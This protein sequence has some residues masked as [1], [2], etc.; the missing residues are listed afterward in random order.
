LQWKQYLNSEVTLDLQTSFSIEMGELGSVNKIGYQSAALR[1]HF[2]SITL[3]ICLVCTTHGLRAVAQK[4]TAT[5]VSRYSVAD[6]GYFMA[7]EIDERPGLNVYGHVAAWQVIGQTHV[8][9]A[10]VGAEGAKLI[11]GTPESSNS[12]AFGISDD[13]DL[14]GILESRADLRYTQ[15]FWYRDG[16]L[17]ILPTLG[18]GSA[19]AKSINRKGLV[20]GNA[21]TADHQ[22]HAATWA[23][24]RVHDLGT[25]LGG[26][27]SRAFDANDSGDI[28]GEAN[29]TVNGKV[30]AVLWSRDR[31][32][33]L[34][35]LPGGSFSSAQ[36]VN[37]KHQVVGFAD[38]ADGGSK[39]VLFWGGRVIDLGSLGDDPSS[40]L[41]INDAGQIV[42]TSPLAEGKM[43]A[44]LWEAGHLYNLNQLI[45]ERS[46]WL[47]LTAYQINAK[48]QILAY[49]FHEGR[50]HA[51][52]LTPMAPP[53]KTSR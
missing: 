40:A 25:L 5:P 36:A 44:F 42:G 2:F 33:D 53:P 50:T 7:R 19:A 20:V 8:D 34:G 49:G 14:V 22:T 12:F 47:L 24:G 28:A 46:G 52:L 31:I 51:C 3:S 21:Q 29:A 37:R 32:H 26:D 23:N 45:P 41:S 11:A 35:I 17:Q 9:A 6:L 39:A 16:S 1:D 48:G 10:L 15:A 30:H 38:D 4:T 43:R 13:D 18:G 27:V